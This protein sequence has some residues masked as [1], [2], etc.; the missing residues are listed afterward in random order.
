MAASASAAPTLSFKWPAK[1]VL[2][3]GTPESCSLQE[4]IPQM[5][6]SCKPTHSP[7]TLIKF[8]FDISNRFG[9]NKQE[10]SFVL[11]G[12]LHLV[13]SK[14]EAVIKQV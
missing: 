1:S 10:G 2:L 3:K 5:F 11:G 7:L 4:N 13:K 14:V 9:A 8:H 12:I 6:P